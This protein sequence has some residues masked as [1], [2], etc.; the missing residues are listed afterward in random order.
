MAP[1]A[2][3]VKKLSHFTDADK[4]LKECDAIET[5]LVALSHIYEQYFVGV[6]RAAPLRRHHRL[7]ARLHNLK[8]TFNRT[9]AFQFRVQ[10]LAARFLAFE[11]MWRR[12]VQEIENG[13]Y[14][15]DLFKAR[16]RG[17]GPQRKQPEPHPPK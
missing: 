5:E 15:R 17:G 3:P 2:E 9:T 10:N 7:R 11:Q 8:S 14:A 12:T 6:E 13:T 4:L 1:T 16:R